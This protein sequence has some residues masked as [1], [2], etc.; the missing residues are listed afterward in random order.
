MTQIKRLENGTIELTLTIPWSNIQ[1]AYDHTVEEE[2][3]QAEIK[4]FRK[5]KAPRNLI[6]PSLDKNQVYSHALQ[7]L[8]PDIYT[9]ALKEHSLKPILYPK[10]QIQSGKENEDWTILATTCE[11]PAVTL[12]QKLGQP[13]YL[14]KQSKISIPDLLAEEETNHRLASLIENITKLGMTTD[15]YLQSKKLTPDTLKSQIKNQA[16]TDLKLEFIL[17]QIQKDHKLETRQKTLD[18]L[19]S[20]K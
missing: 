16:I 14:L 13:D 2:I 6:E 15:I 11:A 7:H 19:S 4:G 17:L 10:I 20:L 12:P 18:F 9:A 5:G 3:S 8:L 1:K